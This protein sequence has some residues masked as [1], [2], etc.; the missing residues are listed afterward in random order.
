MVKGLSLLTEVAWWSSLDL[1]FLRS[2][3]LMNPI[4]TGA[5][6]AGRNGLRSR[7][8]RALTW[9]ISPTRNRIRRGGSSLLFIRTSLRGRGRVA[10]E[11][12]LSRGDFAGRGGPQR[13]GVIFRGF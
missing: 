10:L 12:G 8:G 3:R 11:S 4:I 6:G 13:G 7:G 5:F 2:T 1:F 9:L